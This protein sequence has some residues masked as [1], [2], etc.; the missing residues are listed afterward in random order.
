MAALHL[1]AFTQSRPWS[2]GEFRDLLS[3]PGT[4]ATVRT[5]PWTGQ[6]EALGVVGNR[7]QPI[8]NE[9]HAEATAPR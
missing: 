7:Y 2:E 9:E 4:F 1:A 6:A 5:S 8:Q 3:L